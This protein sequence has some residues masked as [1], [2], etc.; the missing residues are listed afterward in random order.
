MAKATPVQLHLALPEDLIPQLTGLVEAVRGL[1]AELRGT[2]A[3]GVETYQNP[4]FDTA[5]FQ[6]M[7][8]PECQSLTLDQISQ[9]APAAS[10][11]A[12]RQS[13]TA[14]AAPEA[15]ALSS[16]PVQSAAFSEIPAPETF[17]W[18]EAIS[19]PAPLPRGEAVLSSEPGTVPAA[20]SRP[21][22]SPAVQKDPPAHQVE[23]RKEPFASL[24]PQ[25]VSLA[26]RRDH[27]RYDGGFPLCQRRTFCR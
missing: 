18:G 22:P 12:L 4:S 21:L 11:P 7:A 20:Q 26:F 2:V 8:E 5:R 17:S 23:D 3:P 15:P 27:R 13:S 14:P 24:T 1:V 6:S 16:S 9:E 10:A 25:D 19:P